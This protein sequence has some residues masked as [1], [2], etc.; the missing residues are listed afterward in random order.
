MITVCLISVTTNCPKGAGVMFIVI[1][2]MKIKT[3]SVFPYNLH[4]FCLNCQYIYVLKL[5]LELHTVQNWRT[6]EM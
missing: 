6:F 4:N 3:E 2:K 1:C 5:F